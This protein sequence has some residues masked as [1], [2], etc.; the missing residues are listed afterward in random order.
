MSFE[1]D[2]FYCKSYL[3]SIPHFFGESIYHRVTEER[4]V[5]CVLNNLCPLVINDSLMIVLRSH[6]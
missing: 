4:S 2:Y 5:L 6:S 3:C 1:L